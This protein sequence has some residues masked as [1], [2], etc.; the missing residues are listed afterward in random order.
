MWRTAVLV[1]RQSCVYYTPVSSNH[2]A[3]RDGL[4]PPSTPS[5]VLQYF[6]TRHATIYRDQRQTLLD[7][8]GQRYY[9]YFSLHLTTNKN[10]TGMT[11]DWNL[12]EKNGLKEN[13]QK[14]KTFA[15]F[16]LLTFWVHLHYLYSP[17]QKVQNEC[18]N[19]HCIIAYYW[20]IYSRTEGLQDCRT[21]LI[22]KHYKKCLTDRPRPVASQYW[23]CC[24]S[25]CL[26]VAKPRNCK[27]LRRH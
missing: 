6:N 4:H 23:C 18:D 13:C 7:S 17:P 14:T 12:V 21:W 27:M 16:D 19:Q 5:S 9:S 25:L 3:R 22:C 10:S 24:S 20:N 26:W 15:T 2:G 11:S 8:A 1:W